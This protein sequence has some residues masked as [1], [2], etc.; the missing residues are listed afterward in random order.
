MVHMFM[1]K[2]LLTNLRNIHICTYYPT[3]WQWHSGDQK[4][5][6]GFYQH[7]TL[8]LKTMFLNRID[9]LNQKILKTNFFIFKNLFGS[10]MYLNVQ[11]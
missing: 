1:Q 10:F 5:K 2:T 8:S 6:M 7:L 11:V 3:Y 9:P 4:N